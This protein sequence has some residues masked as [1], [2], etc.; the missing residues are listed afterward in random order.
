MYGSPGRGAQGCGKR[1]DGTPISASTGAFT[2]VGTTGDIDIGADD[3]IGHLDIHDAGTITLRDDSDDTS[4]VVGP[5]ADGTTTL[6]VTGGLSIS[7]DVT[8]PKVTNAAALTLESTGAGVV[9]TLDTDA[10]DDF[11]VN[12][13]MLVI[14]GDSGNVGIGDA[15]PAVPLNITSSATGDKSML[16]LETSPSSTNYSRIEWMFDG[17]T[18]AAA[19]DGVRGAANTRGELT[20]YTKSGGSLTQRMAIDED[21]VVSMPAVYGHDM[22]LETIRDLWINDSGE[23]GYDS[24]T[25]RSKVNIEPIG[26]GLVI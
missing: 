15:A 2:T 9:V 6:G 18:V 25:R 11:A 23:L 14:E 13:T 21:G 4:V 1:S 12:T 8:T 10:T 26:H 19:I 22:N 7:G 16:R 24:S 17:S 20:F 5:V 3:D